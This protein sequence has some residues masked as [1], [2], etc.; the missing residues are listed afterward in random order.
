MAFFERLETPTL[1]CRRTCL[2]AAMVD[3][4]GSG[5][6]ERR[7][8]VDFL[9]TLAR[10]AEEVEEVKEAEEGAAG[11]DVAAEEEL[12]EEEDEE[13]E[14]EDDEKEEEREEEEAAMV[15][16]ATAAALAEGEGIPTEVVVVVLSLEFNTCV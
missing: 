8:R 9:I 16:V 13:V 14:E 2:K 6:L 11:A 3:V 15:V 4:D 5:A 12:L 10:G 7:E 1:E